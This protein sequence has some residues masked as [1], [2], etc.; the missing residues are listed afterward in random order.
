MAGLKIPKKKEENYRIVL[1]KAFYTYRN[2]NED[3]ER[4]LNEILLLR[5]AIQ[6]SI[7]QGNLIPEFTK[8]PTEMEKV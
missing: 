4:E 1:L 8:D 7:T 5:L 3:F 6:K 2:T